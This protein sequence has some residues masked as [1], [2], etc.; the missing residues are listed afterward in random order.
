MEDRWPGVAL[1][2]ELRIDTG[3]REYVSFFKMAPPMLQA[4]CRRVV[5]D[6]VF[7]FGT[8][9]QFWEMHCVC[10]QSSPGR[11]V[12]QN[13]MRMV[14]E[15]R[16]RLIIARQEVMMGG[17]VSPVTLS[18]PIFTA[19]SSSASTSYRVWTPFTF[20]KALLLIV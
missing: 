6:Q 9:V 10:F 13:G 4:F 15:G 20:A 7:I 19:L 8:T 12:G 16:K 18:L 1:K 11:C 5:P 2:E 17:E 3:M 14:R